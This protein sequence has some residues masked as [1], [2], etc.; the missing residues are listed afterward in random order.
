MQL[1]HMRASFSLD[2]RRR[3]DGPS[4]QVSFRR[5]L[6]LGLHYAVLMKSGRIQILVKP[7]AKELRRRGKREWQLFGTVEGDD[8]TGPSLMKMVQR[9]VQEVEGARSTAGN[10]KAEKAKGSKAK[11]KTPKGP[12][13]AKH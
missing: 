10:K 7:S 1:T 12:K 3:S 8:N 9:A 5:R 13:T 4:Q 11:G 2:V 6:G